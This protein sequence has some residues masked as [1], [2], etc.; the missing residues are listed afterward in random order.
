MKEQLKSPYLELT[1]KVFDGQPDNVNW[2]GVDYDGLL[3]F[4][5]AINPRTSW[6]SE[7][8]RGFEE[9][10]TPKISPY[11]PL[12]QIHRIAK[13]LLPC[14]FL[15]I[16]GTKHIDD[17]KNCTGPTDTPFCTGYDGCEKYMA[18]E[19]KRIGEK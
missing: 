15:V 11:Q 7:R 6:A 5:V 10:G 16:T 14:A 18:T 2:A 9:I 17:Q 19:I 3:H 13:R 1:Q 4:G 12:T 8:W